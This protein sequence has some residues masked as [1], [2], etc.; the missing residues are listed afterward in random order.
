MWSLLKTALCI[1]PRKKVT[2]FYRWWFIAMVKSFSIIIVTKQFDS[3]SR[4]QNRKWQKLPRKC[5]HRT[6]YYFSYPACFIYWNWTFKP[7]KQMFL[8]VKN[9]KVTMEEFPSQSRQLFW[10]SGQK[11]ERSYFFSVFYWFKQMKPL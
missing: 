2:S 9:K 10:N 11:N 6:W 3:T 4:H 7:N 5:C 1:S 8:S